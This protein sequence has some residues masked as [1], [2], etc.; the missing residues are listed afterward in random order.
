MATNSWNFYITSNTLQRQKFPFRRKNPRTHNNITRE[1]A[2][3]FAR[4]SF[5][6]QRNYK[7]AIM[8]KMG[9]LSKDRAQI[10]RNFLQYSCAVFYIIPGTMWQSLSYVKCMCV[11][12]I[13]SNMR[14]HRRMFDYSRNAE[15]LR[16]CC[17]HISGYNKTIRSWTKTQE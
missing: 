7:N 8:P 16:F 3:P 10:L 2:F 13:E 14:L 1:N 11:C 6:F 12:G 4:E 5:E 9:A 17:W 15:T